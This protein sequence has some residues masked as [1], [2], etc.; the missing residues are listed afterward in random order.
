MTNGHY[1]A[2]IKET[3][4]KWYKYDDDKVSE[5]HTGNVIS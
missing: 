1:F 5:M 3:N 2:Y 4:E